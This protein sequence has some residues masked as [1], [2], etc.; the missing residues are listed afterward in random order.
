MCALDVGM[1]ILR[2]RFVELELFS[3]LHR[4]LDTG[5]ITERDDRDSE[6]VGLTFLIHPSLL[7]VEDDGGGVL[8]VEG[9]VESGG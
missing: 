3:P 6:Q 1:V 2:C 8:L 9:K 7:G 4:A 5:V